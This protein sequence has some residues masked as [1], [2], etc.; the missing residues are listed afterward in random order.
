MEET[1]NTKKLD[2]KT[3]SHSFHLWFWGALTCFSQEHMQTFGYMSSMLPILKK[4]YPNHDD[5]VDA[6]HAYTAFFNTNPMLGTVIIGITAS[7]EEARANGKDID[8]G[9]INDMRAGL[10]GPIAGIGDS[11]IDGTLIP[12]LL[13]ISLGM[14]SGGSPVG[15]IFY[16]IVWVL[17]AY[18]G[19]RLLYFRGYSLGDKAVGF[20]VGKQGSAVRHAISIIGSMVVGGVL[21]SWVNV[22]TSLR[23]RGANGKV[24]LNLQ[25]KLDSIF[26]GLLT[27]AVTFFC[28]WLMA[29]RHVSAI[30]TMLILVA[31]SL[32]GVLLG[33]FNPGL[34]Y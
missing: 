33:F 1:Q 28:W 19:Q 14:S 5:Q 25:S 3:L 17:I 31:I 9:T 6:I 23:L 2:H 8:G 10:M 34:S 24:F 30:W 29:K 7:M 20:L 4:L 18:F 21:A 16:I 12:I 26:P 15:A 22:T 32:V 11:L 13:G 27:V